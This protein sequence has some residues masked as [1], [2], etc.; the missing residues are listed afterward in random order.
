MFQLPPQ[1]SWDEAIEATRQLAKFLCC[2]CWEKCCPHLHTHEISVCGYN[3]SACPEVP[4]VAV[5]MGWVLESWAWGVLK[6]Q[7]LGKVS[8]E[9]V[10][11]VGGEVPRLAKMLDIDDPMKTG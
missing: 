4:A 3:L 10:Q 7:S 2:N 11:W 6:G 9:T 5:T 8:D 1:L